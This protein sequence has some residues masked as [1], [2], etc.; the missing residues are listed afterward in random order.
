MSE[1]TRQVGPAAR[2]ASS[3]VAVYQRFVSPLLGANCRYHP[4]CSAYAREA[5]EIHGVV[6]GGALAL[7]RICRCHPWQP[8]GVDPV[9]A[10]TDGS[11]S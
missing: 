8:G 3:L 5:L 10:R 4:T 7:R 11:H 6:R 1:R 2:A 9:P